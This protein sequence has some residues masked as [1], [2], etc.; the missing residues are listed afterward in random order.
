MNR[1]L[2]PY[3]RKLLPL[4]VTGRLSWFQKVIVESWL[5]RS[6]E[7]RTA[8]AQAASIR[9]A[10]ISRPDV[11]PSQAVF[12]RI[13]EQARVQTAGPALEGKTWALGMLLG[14][15]LAVLAWYAMPPVNV[16]AWSTSGPA[17]SEFRIYRGTGSDEPAGYKLISEVSADSSG[18]YRYVDLW[19]Q[20]GRTAV[21]RVE[22]VGIDG[23]VLTSE[24][25][26]VNDIATLPGQLALLGSVLICLYGALVYLNA[27]RPVPARG[28]M[29][30]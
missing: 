27:R 4:Y 2:A 13:R 10:L 21:Y 14:L 18:A 20:P 7:A 8:L 11:R 19:L 26:P 12:S 23:R 9:K 17:P 6:P 30:V 16:L 15:L 3:C 1:I 24:I 28:W 29:S 25:I 5:A 22:A